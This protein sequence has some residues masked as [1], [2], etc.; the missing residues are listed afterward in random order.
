MANGGGGERALRTTRQGS[1]E[2]RLRARGAV[3]PRS[4][5]I[6]SCY[7]GEFFRRPLGTAFAGDFEVGEQP[8]GTGR[9]R[10]ANARLEA[11][12]RLPSGDDPGAALVLDPGMSPIVLPGPNGGFGLNVQL[13][14]AASCS[15]VADQDRYR[16]TWESADPRVVSVATGVPPSE[17]GSR[18]GDLVSVAPGQTSVRVTA[19]D[20]DTGAQ[21]AQV[22]VPVTVLDVPP[23][24]ARAVPQP[25]PPPGV[26]S[27]AGTGAGGEGPVLRS[28][29][30]DVG[31]GTIT[32]TFDRP[33]LLGPAPLAAMYLVVYG[34][35]P[36]CGTPVGNSHRVITGSGT[37]TLTLDATSLARPT[38]YITL[39]PGFVTSADPS[40][41]SEPVGCT[42]VATS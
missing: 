4:G 6:E 41:P 17:L 28:A 23:P 21:V 15:V 19:T 7:R 34:D 36:S 31:A 2:R 39:A 42:A 8:P 24:S 1:L 13:L 12:R 32:V 18:H 11:F 38:S 27:G 3:T 5:R 40:A 33:V 26:T 35:D 25:S 10:L 20:P 16:Y 37:P 9:L 22:A 30:A 14:D 29:T